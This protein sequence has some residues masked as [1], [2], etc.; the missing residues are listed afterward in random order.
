M[1]II[2]ID[3]SKLKAKADKER[4]VVL[5][6]LLSDTDYKVLPDY[7]R[8]DDD[9]VTQRQAWRDEIRSLESE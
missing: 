6:Q 9:I 4:I 3:Q 7:D 5:K 8:T 2:K 1:S